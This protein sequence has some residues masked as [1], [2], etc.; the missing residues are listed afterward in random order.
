MI[1]V[2][3]NSLAANLEGIAGHEH[4][5]GPIANR[6]AVLF[7]ERL[8]RRLRNVPKRKDSISIDA[9]SAS[10]PNIALTAMSDETVA[11]TIASAWLESVA[12]KLGL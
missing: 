4:R 10:S 9:L 12:L 3:I 5:I 6:A 1:T 11:H 8:N 2:L 7:A